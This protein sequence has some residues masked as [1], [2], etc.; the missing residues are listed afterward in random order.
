M[1]R[2]LTGFQIDRRSLADQWTSNDMEERKSCLPSSV[3]I[4]SA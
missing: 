2:T 4:T 3:S 1:E